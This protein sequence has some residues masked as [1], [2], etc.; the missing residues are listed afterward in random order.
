M[1]SLKEILDLRIFFCYTGQNK[2]ELFSLTGSPCSPWDPAGPP[3]PGAPGA[4]GAP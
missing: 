1:E 2:N 4:P 3:D